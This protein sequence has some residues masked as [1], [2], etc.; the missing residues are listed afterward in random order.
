MCFFRIVRMISKE[1]FPEII[2]SKME[3]ETRVNDLF[4]SFQSYQDKWKM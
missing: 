1:T 4:N 2:N 3:R